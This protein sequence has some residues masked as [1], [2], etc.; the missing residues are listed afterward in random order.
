MS[1]EFI[2][3]NT[4]PASPQV[5]YEED[6][7]EAQLEVVKGGDGP[8]LVLAGAGSGKTR[9]I[10]YRVAYLIESGVP[11]ENILLLTFTNK[12]ANEMLSRVEQL[13]G[14]YPADLWGGTFH[15][16]ANRILRKF[17]PK[18]GYES[19]FTILD[20]EDSK[21]LIK[22]CIKELKI[23]TKARRFPSP[24][25]IQNLISYS[26][27]ASMKLEDVVARKYPNFV[28]VSD[29]IVLVANMYRD[30]KKDA[31][32]MDFDDML[33][34]LLELLKNHPDVC[35]KL[36]NQFRYILVDEFQDTN[37]IQAEIVKQLAHVHE[38]IVVVG[39]DA[40][41]IYSF[42]AAEIKNILSFPTT[43]P[44]TKKFH[45]TINY[46][47]TPQVLDVA[48]AVIKQNSNQ[49]KKELEAVVQGAELPNLVP[50]SNAKQ[51]ESYLAEPTLDLRNEG[52]PMNDMV[53]LFR[54]TFHSQALEMELMKKDI[55]Y[56]YRGGLKF[57]ERAHIK[58]IIAH[59][60]TYSNPKD[61]TAW[62]RVLGHQPGVGLVTAGKIINILKDSASYES[63]IRTD[64]ESVLPAR[65]KAGWQGHCKIAN[66]LISVND[67]PGDLI[68]A[69]AA[70]DYFMYLEAEYPDYRDRLED[71]EQMAIFSE[72]YSDLTKFLQE[73]TL[74]EDYG[75]VREKKAPVDDERL[76]L[77]T[78]HQ[79]KGL[80]WKAVFV[81]NMSQ[82][83]FPNQRALNE[84][85]GLEEERRLFYV[86]STRARKHLYMTYPLTSGFDTLI[87]NSPSMFLSE[88]PDNMYETVKVRE[89]FRDSY[90][91]RRKSAQ[92]NGYEEPTIVFDGDG[93]RVKKTMPTS[94]LRDV[95]EL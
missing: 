94:F 74:K 4:A 91:S 24:A 62:L 27:N 9:T 1:K 67:A 41:S 78:V 42:R 28:E 26:R 7:N 3:T 10:T 49:F 48:N 86:A 57:F 66:K 54:A 56:E 31:N 65:A 85:G 39:D 73:I 44:N 18:L 92:D 88:I 83:G 70:S 47:S 29:A 36:S 15:S 95:D 22:V 34:M 51:E 69:I 46:R 23:D 17:A 64:M 6:L 55:P 58:D 60:K 14:S 77:S 72:S 45:L 8:C 30:R 50:T 75:A 53:V 2:I 89:E 43:Y 84:D 40:Q 37:I 82:G 32:A 33:L 76:V 5:N 38:N 59:L 61:E 93:E 35:D 16:V 25:V 11:A 13:L 80:E 79:A 71:I 68:R 81:M 90:V 21:S 19:N 20:Q 87:L 63:A 52:V 12:A